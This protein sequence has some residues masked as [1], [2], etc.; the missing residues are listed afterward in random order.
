MNQ[1][2]HPHP[3]H[4]TIAKLMELAARELRRQTRAEHRAQLVRVRCG[5]GVDMKESESKKHAR[6]EYA[7]LCNVY[8]G[9]S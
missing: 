4:R 8:V 9:I 2:F 6:R 3:D 7:R 1:T 5:L